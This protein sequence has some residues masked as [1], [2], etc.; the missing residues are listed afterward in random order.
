VKD[1][2]L[3]LGEEAHEWLL[4]LFVDS[5]MQ[6]L[7]VETIAQG[8]VSGV[9]VNFRQIFMRG[10][11][12]HAHG[13]ILVHNHPSGDTTPSASDVEVTKRL[14]QVSTEMQIPLLD[15]LVIA[16]DVMRTVGKW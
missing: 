4:A 15:H 5:Y 2:V 12:L 11:S 9:D 10:M 1:Y 14:Y 13:F 3:S 7:S 6:L 8:T 16:G